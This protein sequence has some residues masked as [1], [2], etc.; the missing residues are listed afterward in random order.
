MTDIQNR[1]K[2]FKYTTTPEIVSMFRSLL[3]ARDIAPEEALAL[4]GAIHAGLRRPRKND[5]SV[6][7]QYARTMALLQHS[8]PDT[9][10]Y[11]AANWQ[12]PQASQTA[13]SSVKA[14]TYSDS[15]FDDTIAMQTP[16][17]K[18][19]FL[20]DR[21]QVKDDGETLEVSEGEDEFG[22]P[23]EGG[24]EDEESEEDEDESVETEEPE[25]EEEEKQ[26]TEE[27]SEEKEESE[28]D[29]IEEVKD[30]EES[31]NEEEWEMD[32]NEVDE[33]GEETEE[34]PELEEEVE[35]PET[36][37]LEYEDISED[38]SYNDSE[39]GMED[40][41]AMAR[42]AAEAAE[43]MDETSYE[44]EPMEEEDPP[45]AED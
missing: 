6:Y 42:E 23:E 29:E 21:E 37:E 22:E 20:P 43:Y 26:E 19:A 11:V 33:S 28:S 41:E 12:L 8:M 2:L 9:D 27:E 25:S 39:T 40:D 36:E 45:W 15:L 38:E 7:A 44:D 14:K 18:Q 5:G 32:E 10:K 34:E 4:A 17:S 30:E 3:D 16:A 24:E 13:S 1:K 35:E 31:D